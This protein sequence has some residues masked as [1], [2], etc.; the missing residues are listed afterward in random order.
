[1]NKKVIIIRNAAATDFGGAE[2]I[3]VQLA[4]EIQKLG[5]EP[6]VFSGSDKLLQYATEQDVP[7]RKTWWWQ[8]QNWSGANALLFPIYIGWQIVLFF[9]YI[10]LFAQIHP[11]TVHVE[12]KDDY[13]AATF[14]ARTLGINVFWSDNADLKHIWRNGKIWYKNPTGKFVYLAARLVKHIVVVS[15]EDRR[16]I[17]EQIPTGTIQRKLKVMYHG[18]FDV[19]KK[20][21]K[22]PGVTYVSTARLVTDKGIGELI[23]AFKK[24]R[25]LHDDVQLNMVG[26]GPQMKEFKMLAQ[27]IKGIS[28]LGHQ[29]EPLNYVIQSDVFVLP[30]YHEG[31]SIAL[32][33]A[34]MEGLAIITTNVG[35]NPEIIVDGKTGLLVEVKNSDQLF[36]AMELLYS[37]AKLRTKLGAAARQTYLDNFDFEQLIKKQWL[38]LYNGE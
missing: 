2:R 33:E 5:L 34:C 10:S 19:Y 12:S 6:V 21:K 23:V 35:G 38:P 4:R 1:M 37:D 24:L 8:R 9:Y 3:A 15:K 28:W 26:D 16:L 20:A 30:T 18:T 29:P 7:H 14:A 13:I 11:K 31:F 32:L 25:A 22:Q 27:S 17:S 36:D